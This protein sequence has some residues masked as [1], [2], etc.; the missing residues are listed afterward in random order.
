MHRLLA[1][2]LVGYA[3]LGQSVASAAETPFHALFKPLRV[4]RV[5]ELYQVELA[6]EIM[7]L[8]PAP[9]N[10]QVTFLGSGTLDARYRVPLG[11][12][13]IDKDRQADLITRVTV[14]E[15]EWLGWQRQDALPRLRIEHSGPAAGGVEVIEA[16]PAAPPGSATGS[17]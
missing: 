17:F 6:I 14:P 16:V 1:L 3:M 15:S 12:T 11:M 13:R 4:T 8:L 2:L 9:T 5:G 7:N 10:A